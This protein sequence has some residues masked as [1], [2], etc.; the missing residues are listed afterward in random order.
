[1]TFAAAD[2]NLPTGVTPIEG[3]VA[4]FAQPLRCSQAAR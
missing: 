4:V 1:M 3:Q 2:V